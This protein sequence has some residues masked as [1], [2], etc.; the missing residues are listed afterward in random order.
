[1]LPPSL[2]PAP[3]AAPQGLGLES[4]GRQHGPRH[5]KPLRQAPV[6]QR[7]PSPANAT[8]RGVS[9]FSLQKASIRTHCSGAGARPCGAAG[10]PRRRMAATWA[11]SLI[12]GGTLPSSG[13]EAREPVAQHSAGRRGAPHRRKFEVGAHKRDQ[14]RL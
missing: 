13:V 2:R 7:T 1:M 11:R 6:A 5:A 12:N 8:K 10:L 4:V 14:R 3:F 9:F